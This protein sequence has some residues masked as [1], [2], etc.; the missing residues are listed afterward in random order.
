MLSGMEHIPFKAQPHIAA[1]RKRGAGLNR[2]GRYESRASEVVDDGW[3]S[4]NDPDLPPLSTTV[5]EDAARS[6]ITRNDSPDI[7]FDRSLNAYRGCEHGCIYCYARPS[8]NWLGL[9]SGLDFETRL[10]AKSRAPELLEAELCRAAY[11]KKPM[12]PLAMGT[13]TDPYQ[14]VERRLRLT[15][16]VLEV[17]R[18][19]NHPF[20]ITTK[21]AMVVRD[22]DILAPLAARGLCAVALSLTTLERDLARVMEPRAT[23]PAGRLEAMRALS[24]AGIPVTVMSAPMIPALNDHEMEAILAAAHNAGATSAGYTLLHLP[25]DLTELFSDW[26]ATHA[27]DRAEHV[28]SLIRQTHQG[29]LN[30]ARFGFR[31]RGTGPI[32]D[33]LH[34]RFANACK[35]LG[36]DKPRPNLRTDLFR[37]P[38]RRG[39]QFKL[40]L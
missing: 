32:A 1:S 36:L 9:S 14:P 40:A 34:L 2:A 21:S 7:P 6:V 13:N 11:R 12:Q 17:L 4:W 38:P 27:P 30:D 19:F 28:L 16:R 25:Y 31:M 23:P 18:D 15:R 26:L 39:E 8:H 33:L 20:T 5:Q 24:A 3:E 35:R 29:C 22:I 37:P 10:F